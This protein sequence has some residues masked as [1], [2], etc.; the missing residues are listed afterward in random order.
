M[1]DQINQLTDDIALIQKYRSRIQIIEEGKK[2]IGQG[3]KYTQRKRNAYKINHNDQYGG[4]MI[5]LPKSIGK[6]RL[7]ASKNGKKV[8]DQPAADFDPIDLLTKRFNSKKNYSNLS[9]TLFD[10]LNKLSEI[11]IHRSS[12]EFS[13]LG[14]GVVYYNNI[15]DL[16]DRLELLPGSILAG[17]NGVQSEFSQVAH[18][19]NKLGAI[20]NNQLSGLLKEYVI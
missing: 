7:V 20:D 13:K 12:K 11:P 1:I 10:Q 8:L 4:I 18:T 16:L 6:L 19:L 3:L 2:T 9:R 5:D 14:S 17:N 15:N